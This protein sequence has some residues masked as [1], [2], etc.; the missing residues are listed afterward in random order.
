MSTESASGIA[1]WIRIVEAPGHV[2][3][4]VEIRGWITH[5][6][7]S[8]KVQFLM[9]RDGSGIRSPASRAG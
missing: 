1:P 7:S 9:I 8:G 6:R 3:Q 5:R 2:E 4:T